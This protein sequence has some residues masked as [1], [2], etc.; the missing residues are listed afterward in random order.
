[1]EFSEEKKLLLQSVMFLSMQHEKDDVPTTANVALPTA[2]AKNMPS[3]KIDISK[4]K[5]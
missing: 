5:K 3:M 2:A 4:Y 1:M